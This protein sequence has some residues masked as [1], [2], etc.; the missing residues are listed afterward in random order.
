MIGFL[1]RFDYS[2]DPKGRVNIPAKFR[3][4]LAPEADETF[5]ITLAPNGCLRAFPMNEWVNEEKR[6]NSIPQ[7]LGN[8]RLNRQIYDATADSRCDA[9]GRITLN[10]TQL[11]ISGIHDDVVLVGSG[12]FVEL[13]DAQRYAAYLGEGQQ[14]DFDA[15]YEKSI[16]SSL[17]GQAGSG[18]QQ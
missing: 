17:G 16:E 6:M 18:R 15:L 13:W 3:K 11:E 1:G 5:V 9:Q 4:C 12:R 10:K 14:S 2:A 7:T 8:I